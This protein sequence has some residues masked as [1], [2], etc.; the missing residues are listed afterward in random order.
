MKRCL[1]C[2]YE[3]ETGAGLASHRRAKHPKFKGANRIALEE[4]LTILRDLG[5]IEDIDRARVQA[6]QSLADQLDGDP[7]NAQMWKCYQ[8]S[9]ANL[10]GP[11][12]DDGDEIGKIIAEINSRA[13][14]GHSPKD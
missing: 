8:E 5:R 12:D 2:N 10:M 3:C 4:T 7:S 13:P 9:L 11:D 14:V 1:I 6:V